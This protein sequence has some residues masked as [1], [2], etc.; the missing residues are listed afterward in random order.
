MADHS[1]HNTLSGYR[2]EYDFSESFLQ[3]ITYSD[4]V[5]VSSIALNKDAASFMEYIL[6]SFV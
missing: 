1:F 6:Y 3:E 5:Q 2:D 4:D